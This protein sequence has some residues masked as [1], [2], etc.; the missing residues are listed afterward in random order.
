MASMA[1]FNDIIN[2]NLTTNIASLLTTFVI[3]LLSDGRIVRETRI[4]II[5]PTK[6]K[7]PLSPQ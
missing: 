6:N 1:K 5:Y 7:A 2:F 4:F 3:A